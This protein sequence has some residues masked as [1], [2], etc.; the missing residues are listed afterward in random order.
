MIG[1]EVDG[2]IGGPPCQGFSSIGKQDISDPRR[3]L[4]VDFFRIVRDINPKFFLMENVKG[5]GYER[6]RHVLDQGLSLLPARYDILGP[7]VL[8]CA[9]FGAATSR[10]R[11]FVLGYDSG[12]VERM[13][14]STF[15]GKCSPATVRDAIRDLDKA[16]LR[17]ID[18]SGYDLWFNEADEDI[19]AYARSLRGRTRIF[20]GHRKTPHKREIVERFSGV[21]QGGKD[22]IG[23]HVRLAWNAQ[24]PTI[25]AGTGS[26][27]G[28][29]QSVRPIHPSKNRVITVREAARLQGF[30]DYFRFHP[31]TW[32]SFRMIGNSVSPIIARALLSTMRN[33]LDSGKLLQEAAE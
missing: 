24:C 12:R 29:Y 33:Q 19:S 18:K 9:D 23:K 27:R 15:L 2:I 25:R 16:K 10:P 7:M 32:H 3:D 26:D 13:N 28:S 6:N 5:L 31:T 21:K 8:D 14:I 20:T 17:G 22:E 4:L 11:I 1:R 30:P